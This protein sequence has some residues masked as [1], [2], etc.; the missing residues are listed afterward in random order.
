M[1]IPGD[2]AF[3]ALLFVSWVIVVALCTVAIVLAMQGKLGA[4]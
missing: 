2:R 1:S 4:K 3:M